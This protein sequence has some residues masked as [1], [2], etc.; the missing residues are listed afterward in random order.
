MNVK[1]GHTDPAAVEQ[2]VF[3]QV[4]GEKPGGALVANPTYDIKTGTAVGLSAGILKPIKALRLVK[5]VGVSDTTIEVE[6][7]SGVIVGEF[8]ANG[9]K[10]V[11]VTAVDTTTSTVKDIVTAT[12]GLVIPVGT[13]LYQ[14]GSAS[15]SAATPIYTPS[16]L[17]GAPVYAGEGDQLVRVI[18]IANVRKETVNASTEVLAL[19]QTIKAV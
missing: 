11:A 1:F 17:T 10:S 8:I 13:V 15:A 5:A 7:G 2:V 18:N 16:F 14:A 4:L 9:T 19:L 6:K 3:E 12:L